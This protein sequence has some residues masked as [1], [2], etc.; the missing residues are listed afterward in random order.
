MPGI[1]AARDK[2]KA[3]FDDLAL[4]YQS[5]LVNVPEDQSD[6][7]YFDSTT[8]TWGSMKLDFVVHQKLITRMFFHRGWLQ[9]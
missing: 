6:F 7:S 5:P 9:N 4:S 3:M 2:I 8:G 1:N